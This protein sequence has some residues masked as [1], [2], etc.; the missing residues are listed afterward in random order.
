[1]SVDSRKSQ[2][3]YLKNKLLQE[4]KIIPTI[5]IT[6]HGTVVTIMENMDTFQIIASRQISD[7]ISRNG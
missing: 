4:G 1:M 2:I 3:G 7:E 5:V 6:I